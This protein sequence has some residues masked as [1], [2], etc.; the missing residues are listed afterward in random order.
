M[1]ENLLLSD[2]EGET[3]TQ[4]I[5]GTRLEDLT[6]IY[7]GRVVIKGS[8]SLQNVVVSSNDDNLFSLKRLE[9]GELPT[10]SPQKLETMNVV[11]DGIPFDLANVTKQYWM[12]SL[13]QVQVTFYVYVCFMRLE[14][15][16]YFLNK[17]INF[18]LLILFN[19]F[20]QSQLHKLLSIL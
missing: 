17:F 15:L 3:M 2:S 10:V 6:Q 13:D 8:L 20:D 16:F 18:R 1:S 14:K 19:S 12:K 9:V 7:N 4:H 5:V 11:V